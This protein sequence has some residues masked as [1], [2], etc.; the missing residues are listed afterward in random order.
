[1]LTAQQSRKVQP[2]HS[3]YPHS[4]RIAYCYHLTYYHPNTQVLHHHIQVLFEAQVNR[5]MTVTDLKQS[6]TSRDVRQTKAILVNDLLHSACDFTL[7]DVL[8]QTRLMCKRTCET[9]T[10]DSLESINH[11]SKYS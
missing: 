1:M 8:A 5:L 10:V 11:S 9:N 6:C 2:A 4:R 7:E 3:S